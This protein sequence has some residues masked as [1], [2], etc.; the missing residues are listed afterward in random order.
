[1]VDGIMETMKIFYPT[2]IIGFFFF[3]SSVFGATC[4]NL[5]VDLSQRS[6]GATVTAL[7]NFLKDSGY[8]SAAPNGYFGPA[9]FSAVK[10]FQTENKI[11][12]TGFVGPATRAAIRAKSCA[13]PAPTPSQPVPYVPTTPTSSVTLPESGQTLTIGKSY[14]I[15]WKTEIKGSYD[16]IL[17]DEHGVAKGYIASNL[18]GGK[19]HEWK[20]GNIDSAASDMR[21][22]PAGSYKI[23]VRSNSSA[24]DQTSGV[25]RLDGPA[26][27]VNSIIP[28][29]ISNDENEAIVLYGRGFTSATSVY[30]DGIRNIRTS[31]LFVSSDGRVLVFSIPERLSSGTH[32]ISLRNAYDEIAAAG[33]FSVE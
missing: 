24:E 14:P 25:F 30:I 18:W 3:T 16:I 21:I 27:R 29:A 12:S 1:V 2:F 7:Q 19:S 15:R 13:A 5:S 9:T 23:R 4:T 28:S 22:A 6:T 8:L 20:A 10:A 32:V 31:R 17:E 33:T 11:D 26:L